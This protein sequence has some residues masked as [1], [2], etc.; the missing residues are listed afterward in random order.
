MQRADLPNHNDHPNFI[1]A[2]MLEPLS[3]CDELITHFETNQGKQKTGRAGGRMNLEAKNSIDITISPKE[4]N[5]ACNAVFKAYFESL[6]DCYEDYVTQWP[7]LKVFREELHIGRFN[8]QRYQIG[9]HF[10]KVH[11]ERSSLRNLDRL[12][13]WM[14]YLNDVDS[15]DGG[16]TVFTHYGLAIQPKKGLTLIWPA[17][18]THAHKGSVLRKNSKYII[19]GWMHF[20]S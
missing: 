12:F 20:P 2:W 9:Q 3:I 14:T 15:N 8:L 7:F 18:W 17:E 4:L 10:Q 16:A 11:T 19:T 5:I 1:G 13:A 6:F